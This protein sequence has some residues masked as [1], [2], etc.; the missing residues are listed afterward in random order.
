MTSA[1]IGPPSWPTARFLSPGNGPKA[2]P[3]HPDLARFLRDQCQYAGV[4]FFFKQWGAWRP[5]EASDVAHRCAAV[6]FDGSIDGGGVG[7]AAMV[8][9]GKTAAG[10][11]YAGR[12]P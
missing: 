10:R 4:A 8:R 7:A 6:A 12:V 1:F 11:A 5:A 3:M 9:V 2:R